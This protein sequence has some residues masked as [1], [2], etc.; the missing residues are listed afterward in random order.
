MRREYPALLFAVLVSWSLTSSATSSAAEMP[1]APPD[2]FYR[3][4]SLGGGTIAFAA[5]GDLWR[6]P[7]TGGV[8]VRLT[9]FE[10]D[11]SLPHVSPD[12]KWIAFTAEYEG[13]DNVYV[14][15]AAGG[16]PS[17][18]DV[19]PGGRSRPRLDRRREDHL[20]QQPRHAPP[21]P[22]RLF[23]LAAGRHPGAR[24]AR[25]G[26]VDRLRAGR[27]PG[28]LRED[29]S[30]DPQLEALQGRRGRAGLCRDACADGVQQGHDL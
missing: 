22:P 18:T 11:E 25:T 12:G 16:E 17:P 9:A 14:M 3:Q 23:D 5:E 6:V 20:S 10:G 4:P 30:R 13:H 7:V 1:G 26:G 28:G 2:G 24:A 29:R 21:R 8:A 27:Q 19:S 15:S